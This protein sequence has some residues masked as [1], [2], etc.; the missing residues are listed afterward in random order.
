VQV[1]TWHPNNKFFTPRIY[2]VNLGL[3]Q[4]LGHGFL[5][6]IAY[7]GSRGQYMTT[8]VDQNPAIYYPT[9]SNGVAC[10]LSTDQ[11]RRY[12]NQTGICNNSTPSATTFSNI[13]QQSNSGNSWYHSASSHFRSH[14][15]TES[16]SSRTIPSPRAAIHFPTAPMPPPLELLDI[17]FYPSQ[18]PISAV[19]IADSLNITIPTCSL[20]LMSGRLP[21]CRR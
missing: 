17:T 20:P 16:L 3:E 13:Y 18:L 6:R 14:F 1:F 11:R 12:N 5:G 4:D 8:T 19:T 7:V 9:S 10:N 15:R 2:M 21:H